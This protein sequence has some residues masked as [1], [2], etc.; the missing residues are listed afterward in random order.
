VPSAVVASDEIVVSGI[1]TPTTVTITGGEYSING[2]AF[3]TAA[4]VLTNGQR[5]RLRVTGANQFSATSSAVLTVGG[6]SA[7]FTTT[8]LAADTTPNAFSFASQSSVAPATVFTSNDIVIA[9]LNTNAAV[10]ITGGEYSIDGGA[11]SANAGS[12]VNDQHIRVRLTSSAQFATTATATLTVGTVSVSF[13]ATT[14]PADITPEAFS[15]ASQTAVPLSTLLTSNEITIAG[16]N[17]HAIVTITGGEYSVDGG[18]FTAAAGSVVNNQRIRVRMTS[19][20]QFTTAVSAALTVGSVSASFAATTCDPDPIPDAFQIARKSGGT[21]DAWVASDAVLITG[22]NTASPVTIENGEYSLAGGAF[23]SAAGFIVPGQSFVVR[24]RAASTYSRNTRAR[25]TIG[26]VSADFDV[27]SELPNY[28]PDGIAYDGQDVIYLLSGANGLLFRWSLGEARYLDPYPVGSGATAPTSMTYLA[29]HHRVYLGY[30]SGAIRQID[31]SAA[32]PVETAFASMSGNVSSLGSAGNFLVAQINTGY[33][34]GYLLNSSGV[35]TGQGGYYYGYSRET[36]WDPINARVYFTR[37]GISPND[38][39]YDVVDQTTGVVASSGETPYHGAYNIQAPIR[40]SVDGAYVLLGSGDIYAEATLN[41][42]GSLG[43]NVADARWFANG[44]LV[45]LTTTGNNTTLRRLRT[46]GLQTLEQSTYTGQALR[47][48]GTDTRMAVVVA[49]NNTVQIHT[50]VPNDD[51]DGDGVPNTEDAFPQDRAASV[52]TDQD[53]YPDAWN[54][55]STQADS[56]TGLMLDAFAQDSACWLAAHGSGGLCNY[57]ATI[58]DYTPDQVLRNGDVVYLLSSVNKRVYRWSIAAGAYLN[59]YVVGINQGFT[60]VAPTKIAYAPG[61]QR[62]YLGYSTGAIRYIDT[63]GSS[64]EVPFANTALAVEGLASVGNFLLAQD[65]SGAWATHYIFNASGAVADQADWNYYSRDYAWDPVNSRVYFFRDDTSPND[66]HYEVINQTTGEITAAGE[67]PYHGTYGI[68]PPI[69][70][71]V[72][73]QNVL[74]GSGDIFTQPVLNWSGSLGG[75]VTDA[76]WFADGS[77]VTLSSANHQTTL[78]RLASASLA[79]L[80]QLTFTGDALRVVGT[81]TSMVVLVINNGTVQFRSY[82]PDDDSDDD[83]VPNTQDGFPLDAAAS[84]DSDHDGYPDAWNAGKGPADSTT[85][86]TLDAFPQDSACWLPSH[87][88]GGICNNAATIPNFVPDKIAQNGDVIYLLSSANKR[89]YRWSISGGAYLNP[90]VV[91]IN[92]GFT[93]VAPVS[94]EYSVAHQRL[95]LGYSTGAIRYIDVNGSSAEVPFATMAAGVTS[96]ASAGNFLAAQVSIGYSGGFLLNSSGAITGQGGYYYGYSRETAWDPVNSR[97]YYFRDGISPNDLHY[98]VVNQTTGAVTATGETPYHGDYSFGGVIRVAANGANILLGTGDMYAQSTMTWSASLGSQ[99]ADA[100]WLANG[101]LVTLATSGNQTSLRRFGAAGLGVLEQA[102]FTGQALRVMGSDATMVVVVLNNGVVQFQTYVPNNDSDGDGVA[103]T[104][105]AFPLDVAASADADHD[106]YPDAWNTGHSQADS[107]TGL[108]LDA[109]PQDA[110]CWLAAHGSGGVCNYGATVP[111]FI[112]DKVVQQGDVVYLLSSANKRVYRW[113]ISN[114]AYL[115]P[116]VVGIDQGFNSAAPVTIES[117]A[118][119]QRLYVGYA[120]GGIRYLDATV[121]NPSEVAFATPGSGLNGLTSTG[122]FLVAHAQGMYGTTSSYVINSSGVTTGTGSSYYYYYYTAD[123]AWDPVNSRLY[124]ITNGYSS[125]ALYYEV[126]DQTTGAVT[127]TGSSAYNSSIVNRPPARVSVN[128]QFI[129]TGSGDFYA[130]SG[131][132]WVGSLGAQIADARWFANGSVATLTTANNQTMLRR[133][134]SSNLAVLEQRTFTGEAL[135]VF[136][137]DTLMTVLVINNG[138]VQ[139]HSYVPNDDSDGDGVTNTLDAFPLDAAASVDTDRDGYPDSWNAGKTQGDSTTG[140][141]LDAF[142]T[143]S[144]CWLAAHGSGGICNYAATMPNYTPDQVAQQGD[145]VYL[146]S[147][148]NKRVYRWSLATGAYLSPYIVGVDL[149]LSTAAPAAMGYSASHHRLY[150]GYG[151]GAVRYIDVTGAGAE[152]TLTTMNGAVTALSSAGNFL[153]AQVSSGYGYSTGYV[154]NSNGVTTDQS[155]GYYGYPR[156]TA[157]DAATSRVYYLR[158]GSY[159]TFLYDVIDQGTGEVT[160]TGESAYDS[161]SGLYGPIRLSADGQQILLGSGDIYSRSGLT[162][163][164]SLGK[165]VVDAQWRGNLIVDVDSTDQVEIRDASSHAVLHTLQYTSVQ[166][167]RVLVGTTEGYLMHVLNGTTAFVR[168]PLYDQDGDQIAHWFEQHYGLSDANAAD[169]LSDLDGDGVNN[170]TEFLNL[171][172][173]T[174]TDTDADGLTDSDEIVTYHTH[175]GMTDTDGDG[176][177]DYAEVTTYHSDPL[178]TDSDD[179]GYTDRDEVLYGGD[180]NDATGLPQPL[181]NYTQTFEGTPNLVA[182]TSSPQSSAP[183]AIDA[184]TSHSGT[185]SFKSG[186]IDA[187]QNSA[188]RFR[189]FFRPGSLSYFARV[190]SGYCCNRMR[191]YLDG[192]EVHYITGGTSWNPYTIQIPLGIHEIEWRFERDYY[193]GQTTDAAWIDDIVFT[194]Q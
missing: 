88:S 178:D 131:L 174:L 62:L 95:Y 60:T 190:D 184:T 25:I 66:L 9:G 61:N 158:D 155:S 170:R 36:A 26:T 55:G 187:S 112:P 23:T 86:L 99:I 32:S 68:Q 176:L 118:A 78:R 192:S 33:N 113:S 185:A 13:A 34:G 127:S 180:P 81:D 5:V 45:T 41:W 67:T 51:V 125:N 143:E 162:S 53:G 151:N 156:E 89:V 18:A 139:F 167:L 29:A 90:Y 47:V 163:S 193:G 105:D 146:L 147:S 117:S 58:P 164:G 59:P 103:N 64:A 93:T 80:E 114:G 120:A 44:S 71:S 97:L 119:H 40:V 28:L 7:T 132:T 15:F 30:A 191:V 121:G 14:W 102:T 75:Q 177:S 46:N 73:G 82:V 144:A 24:T 84:V 56:T 76:R 100:R 123:H 21:R 137:S 171:S 94:M 48:V 183:W 141:A 17:T 138:T 83:G 186:T 57:G 42:A 111:N 19:S 175:P 65:A 153:L 2:G 135:R 160:S 109:F 50:Y 49:S 152:V 4:G 3:T 16:M 134:G 173:P 74:L 77:L 122:N 172:N 72:D 35:V 69:R 116:Y 12:V 161:N 107:T 52:D 110:A 54:T 85:G 11:F 79:V 27:T 20:A 165:G 189:G 182:W 98:D 145:V 188:V 166:P 22:I 168:L 115:N 142:P 43:T 104:L 130:Q 101:S 126:I 133:L 108:T 149:G 129:L 31:V 150:L 39:H 179:D 124:Y 70:V 1:N 92:Q 181:F 8:T 63:A 136:G 194:G 6:V 91:G 96:L 128:G 38:L 169:A 148:T 140:L 159:A 37:D 106:G 10:T 87:G 154:L 157:W